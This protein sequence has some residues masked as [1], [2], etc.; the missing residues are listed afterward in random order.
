MLYWSITTPIAERTCDCYQVHCSVLPGFF[1]TFTNIKYEVQRIVVIKEKR[2]EEKIEGFNWGR[3][4][5]MLRGNN[6]YTYDTNRCCT[7]EL[8]YHNCCIAADS[9]IWLLLLH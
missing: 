3:K 9:D 7:F 8:N 5:H 1:M 2:K 4:Y 6:I